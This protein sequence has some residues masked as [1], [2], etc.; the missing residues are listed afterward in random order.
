MRVYTSDPNNPKTEGQLL[1][2]E[3]KLPEYDYMGYYRM[4]EAPK[5]SM[6]NSIFTR[7]VATPATYVPEDTKSTT[8]N[9]STNNNRAKIDAKVLEQLQTTAPQP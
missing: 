8:I 4:R 9:P 7:G 3:G 6:L 5:N 1:R 2:A